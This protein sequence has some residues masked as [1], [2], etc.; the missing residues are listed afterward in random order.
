MVV[1]IRECTYGTYDM[2]HMSRLLCFW[3]SFLL[4][5]FFFFFFFFS[6]FLLCLCIAMSL[7]SLADAPLLSKSSPSPNT[8]LTLQNVYSFPTHSVSFSL[9]HHVAPVN[10]PSQTWFVFVF[11]LENHQDIIPSSE[12]QW[13][14]WD[15]R[16]L[17]RRRYATY[18]SYTFVGVNFRSWGPFFLFLFIS[19]N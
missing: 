18:T 4:F 6:S 9:C 11:R 7:A 1:T 3:S 13:S 14:S 12:E 15:R 17:S 5:F 8:G 2:M 16:S 10:V 19:S